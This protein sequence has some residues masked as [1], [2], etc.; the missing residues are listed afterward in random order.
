LTADAEQA[1]KPG[2]T[3]R[4]CVK[5]CPEMVVMP[6]GTFTMGSPLAE[7]GRD[8]S[9]G[10]QQEVTLAKPFAVSKFEVT[11][12][13]WDACAAHGD[14]DPRVS[15][16]GFG[17]GKKPVINVTW[18]DAKRYVA[19]LSRMT[20][21]PYRLLS[22]AEWEYAARAGTQTKYSWG[23]EIGE[24]NANCNGCGSKWDSQQTAPAGSF[25]PNPFGLYDMHGNVWEW[26]EDPWHESYNGAPSDG[27]AWAEDGDRS[28]RTLRSGSWDLNP[29]M[30]RSAARSK[31][32]SD[33]RSSFAGFRVGRTLGE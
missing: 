31:N 5:D 4:E 14:C 30:L 29:E 28:L 21:K 25:I 20:S 2:D 6:A 1:L 26:V 12:D 7:N 13:D 11:F 18:I 33:V 32:S 19:W 9:E 17:R 10:P 3:F 23:E 22:E 16:S 27:S 8:E 24:G 15:D